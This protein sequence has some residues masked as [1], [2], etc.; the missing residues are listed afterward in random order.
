MNWGKSMRGP[1]KRNAWDFRSPLS[2]SAI[3]PLAFTVSPRSS[4]GTSATERALL[5]F[6][7]HTWVREQL[8]VHFHPLP[9]SMWLLFYIFSH[10]TSVQHL[11][12][13]SQ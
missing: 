1:F 7:H 4:V 11:A 12:G 13:G 2:P 9:V 6:N 10:R 8:I 5:S 3:T